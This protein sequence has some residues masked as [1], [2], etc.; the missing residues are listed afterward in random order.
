MRGEGNNF[1]I[2]LIGVLPTYAIFPEVKIPFA[3]NGRRLRSLIK[4][5][6]SELIIHCNVA[7]IIIK[8]AGILNVR[9]AILFEGII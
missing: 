5:A 7:I 8:I 3:R 4:S 6:L 9:G 2:K 1:I